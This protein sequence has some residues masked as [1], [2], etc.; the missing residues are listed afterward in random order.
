MNDGTRP[1]VEYA[2]ALICPSGRTFTPLCEMF[3]VD[4]AARRWS[5]KHFSNGASFTDTGGLRDGETARSL[6]STATG[7]GIARYQ[8]ESDVV[9]V[10]ASVDESLFLSTNPSDWTVEKAR[11]LPDAE[12]RLISR[13]PH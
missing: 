7:S 12:I 1:T 4:R 8:R 9:F 5:S 10:V 3:R 11:R 2:I 6:A 13:A